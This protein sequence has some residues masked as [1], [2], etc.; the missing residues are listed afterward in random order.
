MHF[1]IL[2]GPPA[3]GKMT[4]GLEIEKQTGIKLFHNHMTIEPVLKIFDFGTPAFRRLVDSFR[5]QIFEEAA[6][7]DLPGL[8]FTFVWNLEDKKDRDFVMEACA[9][10]HEAGA[11]ISI[12]ELSANL[13]KRLV[14]NKLAD[15]LEAKPSK[16]NLAFSEKN[17][18][19][20]HHNHQL[21]TNGDDLDIPY[22]HISVDSS[23]LS[24]K[25]TAEVIIE[26]LELTGSG[27]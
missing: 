9:P 21:N 26:K 3:V 14:R 15:R 20:Y 2:F 24:A 25:E 12:V 13:E 18:L 23:D 22:N 8:M 27:H 7:S 17:L 16:R 5:F 19:D 1:I 6:K 10:F 11:K 4:V